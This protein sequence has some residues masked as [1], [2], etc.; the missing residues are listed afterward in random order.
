MLLASG[1]YAQVFGALGAERA[2]RVAAPDPAVLSAA[3]LT[4]ARASIVKIEGVAPSCS[5][6]DR[7]IRV[8]RS[9]PHHVLTNAHV[10]AGVTAR[11]R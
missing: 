11:Q 6:P 9:R 3:G 10:V 4:S 1:P 8:R 2:L 5:R 7:G